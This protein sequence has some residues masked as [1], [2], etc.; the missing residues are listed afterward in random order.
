M[1]ACVRDEVIHCKAKLKGPEGQE[2]RHSLTR[3]WLARRRHDGHTLSIEMTDKAI[4]L[5]EDY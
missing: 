3:D 1:R 4:K 5:A 2:Y